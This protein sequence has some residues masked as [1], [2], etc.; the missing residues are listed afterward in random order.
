MK[1]TYKV[2]GMTCNGCVNS[3]TRAITTSAPDAKVEA[4]LDAGTVTVDGAATVETIS[5]AVQ[6]A[7]FE[8]AGQVA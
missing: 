4:S 1:T 6:D 8:F 2:N 5:Q 3:V 7:G